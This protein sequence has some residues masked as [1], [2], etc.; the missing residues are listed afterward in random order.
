MRTKTLLRN[1]RVDFDFEFSLV[2]HLVF[3]PNVAVVNCHLAQRLNAL[4]KLK[5]VARRTHQR[6]LSMPLNWN[7]FG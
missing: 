3:S 1:R 5:L 6:S 4:I 7:I 2:S